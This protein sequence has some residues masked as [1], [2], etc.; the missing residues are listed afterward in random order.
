MRFY[1]TYWRIEMT[2]NDLALIIESANH[3]LAKI[4]RDSERYQPLLEHYKAL[5]LEQL[6]RAKESK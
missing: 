5:L 2:N 3:L 1:F 4:P 6:R